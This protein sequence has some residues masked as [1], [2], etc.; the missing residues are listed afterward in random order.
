MWGENKFWMFS[1]AVVTSLLSQ[2]LTQLK[3]GCSE[4]WQ[5]VL[6][7]DVCYEFTG[8]HCGGVLK[9]LGAES[10]SSVFSGETKERAK[11]TAQCHEGSFSLSA[12]DC[13]IRASAAVHP[14]LFCDTEVCFF[15]CTNMSLRKT[16]TLW[17][18]CLLLPSMFIP[19]TQHFFSLSNAAK[20]I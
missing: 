7:A 3:S 6:W 1:L 10:I 9:C 16:N 14:N 12:A 18:S 4:I 11:Q 19:L 20:M 13:T 15:S 5:F 8:L 17:A 2:H